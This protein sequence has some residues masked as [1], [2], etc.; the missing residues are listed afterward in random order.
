[1]TALKKYMKLE[2]S[3]LWRAAPGD[4]RREVV[5]SLGEASL[6][7]SDGRTETALTHWSLPAVTRRNPG[8]LP[9]LYTPGDDAEATETL[10][11]DDPAMI[12]AIET[13]RRAL[14]GSVPHPGRLRLWLLGGVLAAA[15]ALAVFWLPRALVEHAASVV[16]MSKRAEIGRMA[17]A[18]LQRLTGAP[19]TSP[20]A[21]RILARLHQR[22]FGPGPG[23]ILVMRQG[24]R[25]ALHLPGRMV[26][27]DRHLLEEF[28]TPEVAAGFTL[29]E[30]LRA[31]TADP[32]VPLLRAAGIGA[33][34]RLLTTGNLPAG[35][36]AGYGERLLKAPR[37]DL[38]D[39]ALLERFAA[40]G[41]ASTPYALA[42]DPSGI[43]VLPLIEAD[44]ARD[45][46]GPL[47]LSD[48][49]WIRLQGVCAP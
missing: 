23:E 46:Q 49:D 8:T 6:M 12:E 45:G 48:A 7:L 9:A 40:A 21:E 28:D 30:R 42:L 31:E 18:D 4:Q 3:G 34:L 24:F 1:M 10:E 35:A 13:V 27:L 22:L 16:P 32:L 47:L 36:V 19:C 39:E 44:P 25:G 20:Q 5:V 41:V 15:A 43:E 38:P 17:R 33:T 29:A 14:E 11:L 26:L 2:C 37:P